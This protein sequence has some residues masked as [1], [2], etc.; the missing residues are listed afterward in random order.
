MYKGSQ[1]LELLKEIKEDFLTFEVDSL[2]SSMLILNPKGRDIEYHVIEWE[3]N[4]Q[5]IDKDLQN[6]NLDFENIK[7]ED[8]E[9]SEEEEVERRK[10]I[11]GKKKIDGARSGCCTIF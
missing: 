5:A 4:T 9:D 3:W 11:D 8:L 7:P 1:R 2:C 6:I 10:S